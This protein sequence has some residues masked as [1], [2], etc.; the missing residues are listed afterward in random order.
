M[1]QKG[2][3]DELR[4]LAA[5]PRI[6]YAALEGLDSIVGRLS[7]HIDQPMRVYASSPA[8]AVMNFGASEVQLGDGAGRSVGPLN[9]VLPVVVVGTI[10]WQSGATTGPTFLV[11]GAAFA[12][13]ATTI[14]RY[15]RVVFVLQSDGSI[16]LHFSAEQTTLGALDNVGPLLS[17]IDGQ[18]IGWA[19]VEATAATA[20]KTVGS[21]TAVIENAVSGVARIHRFGAG[22]GGGGSGDTSFKIQAVATPTATLKGGY[23][24]LDDGRE[25]ATYDGAGT[26]S[27]DFGGNLSLNLSTIFG[28]APANATTY[29]LYVDLQ[30]LGAAVVVTGTGRKLFAVQQANFVLSTTTP[31]IIDRTRY[32]A[33]G[34]VRSA[35]TG[36]VWSGT[37]S[38]FGNLA[39]RRADNLALSGPRYDQIF[40][41]DPSFP[42]THGLGDGVE[43]PVV[44]VQQETTSGQWEGVLGTGN[45]RASGTQILGSLQ[46]YF[47]A[48]ALRVRLVARLANSPVGVQTA[49]PLTSGLVRSYAPNP[50]ASIN[51]ISGVGYT[52]LDNDGF[53]TVL[54]TTGAADRTVVLP[55]AANNAGRGLF[56]KKQDVGVGKVIVDG[57]GAETIDGATTYE[58]NAQFAF[59]RVKCTGTAW[60][61]TG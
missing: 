23:I 34:F 41:S 29:Y 45:V 58:I 46:G 49:T 25:L 54:V 26:A 20:F 13:P 32:V 2:F 42:I 4:A 8:S 53:D 50:A 47:D 43:V 30:T 56:F 44:E 22:A 24:G 48:G 59:V 18:A 61:I 6:G 52:V 36:T 1:T 21:A 27:T 3:L 12:L 11:D 40:S 35:T 57:N 17:G 7:Q 60:V 10:N 37:G 39:L 5:D 14:G 16:N 19:E 9:D 31:D 33:V 55:L 28:G 38:A 15:R 51:S